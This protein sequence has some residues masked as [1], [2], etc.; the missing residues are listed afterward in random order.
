MGQVALNL[1]SAVQLR[2][3]LLRFRTA[4]PVLLSPLTELCEGGLSDVKHIA[5]PPARQ[6]KRS[7]LRRI[8]LMAL[9]RGTN[10]RLAES[11][12]PD[13]RYQK[14]ADIHEGLLLLGCALICWNLL[15]ATPE[16]KMRSYVPDARARAQ[17]RFRAP[18]A[19][20]NRA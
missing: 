5:S 1:N 6:A 10:L 4:F 19:Y 20:S 16:M 9:G 13:V 3:F 11:V 18:E 7:A 12:S 15:S 2:G 17:L 8:G 14:R